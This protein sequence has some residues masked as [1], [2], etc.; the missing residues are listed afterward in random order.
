MAH[1][2]GVKMKRTRTWL[3]LTVVAG[4]LAASGCGLV[5]FGAGAAA[6]VGAVAYVGGALKSTEQVP[7]DGVWDATVA[8][9]KDLQFNVVSQKKD[10][11]S[12]EMIAHTADGRKITLKR[13]TDVLTEMN[14]RVDIFGDESLSRL[15]HDKI[16]QGI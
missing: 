9:M 15:I 4:L 12:A 8:A 7:I 10:A 2:E 5:L 13:V 1:S 11:I 14:I 16:K 3:A 6:G